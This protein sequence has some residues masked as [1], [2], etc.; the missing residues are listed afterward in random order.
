[1]RPLYGWWRGGGWFLKI[2]GC[3]VKNT[4]TFLHIAHNAKPEICNSRVAAGQRQAYSA[5][6]TRY[7][8]VVAG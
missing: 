3:F 2:Q 1:L 7:S 6:V 8:W 5:V 4:P